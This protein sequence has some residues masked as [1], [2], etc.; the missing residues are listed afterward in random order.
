MKSTKNEENEHLEEQFKGKCRNCER[1]VH[2]L[3]QCKNHSSHSCGNDNITTG[4][5]YCSYCR[6]SGHVR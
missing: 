4:G 2:M 6:K 1:I 5:N 3:F